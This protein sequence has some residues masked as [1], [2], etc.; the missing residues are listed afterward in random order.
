MS[1]KQ[2]KKTS[3]RITTSFREVSILAP[4]IAATHKPILLRGPHGVGKSEVVYQ[5]AKP[6]AKALGL[7]D[8]YPQG[9]PVVERRL[10]QCP[11]AGDLTGLPEIRDGVTHLNPMDWF[12]R[13]CLEPCLFFADEIDRAMPDVRQAFFEIT[14]S[15]KVA[16]RL[17]HKDTIIVGAINGGTENANNYQVGEMDPAELDRW[18]VFD[19]SPT[20]SEWLEYANAQRV[21][22]MIT[23]FIQSANEHLEH[24][25]ENF[26]P[27]KIYPSR[28]S[29]F[30]LNEV[31]EE[32]DLEEAKS[33]LPTLL[34][35]YVGQE[36]SLA[37]Y[38]FVRQYSK[39]VSIED[40]ITNGK[41][42]PLKNWKQVEF[43]KFMDKM[44][45]H[46]IMDEKLSDT[47]KQNFV[48]L[49][50]M[51]S[52]ETKITVFQNLSAKKIGFWM[53]VEGLLSKEIVELTRNSLIHPND[54]TGKD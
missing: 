2:K 54:M 25:G 34:N 35:A 28:R 10:S 21:N 18:V 53:Q 16:G 39:E 22:P 36:A 32:K 7:I 44:Y 50:K 29:W 19:V 43:T 3:S 6:F 17:L 12:N 41:F 42:S 46:A 52:A 15:R 45:N 4:R 24:D 51:L 13:I 23:E 8:K 37:F 26:I 30:R 9:L 48:R 40:V 47:Q 33:Y 5:L 11:D 14:D 38:E 20:V 31:L 27:G 1:T 49:F